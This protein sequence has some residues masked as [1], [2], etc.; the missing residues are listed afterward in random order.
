MDY[1]VRVT[2]LRAEGS[3]DIITKTMFIRADDPAKA[4]VDARE[5]F[6]E[7]FPSTLALRVKNIK[8]VH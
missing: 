3:T 7:M 4:A 1:E 6:H 8:E 2:A 5:K